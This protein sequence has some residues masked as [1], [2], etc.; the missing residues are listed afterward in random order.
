MRLTPFHHMGVG[1]PPVGGFGGCLMRAGT[2]TVAVAV[3]ATS[4]RTDTGTHT[5]TRHDGRVGCSACAQTTVEAA[6]QAATVAGCTHRCVLGAGGSYASYSRLSPSFSLVSS[7]SLFLSS[8]Y[9]TPT[10]IIPRDLSTL[11]YI[12]RHLPSP[13]CLPDGLCCS[14]SRHH[15]ASS[16]RSWCR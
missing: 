8:C 12:A 15:Q 14:C 4:S 9:E 11:R 10:M 16:G 6:R 7:L 1:K 2:V 13:I 5:S 3:A